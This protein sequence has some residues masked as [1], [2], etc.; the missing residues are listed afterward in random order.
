MSIF[1][2]P[3]HQSPSLSRSAALGYSILDTAAGSTLLL[4]QRAGLIKDYAID[5]DYLPLPRLARSVDQEAGGTI[6]IK[7]GRMVIIIQPSS[8]R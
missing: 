8:V 3:S 6:F 4:A 1:T 7:L 5:H 2:D